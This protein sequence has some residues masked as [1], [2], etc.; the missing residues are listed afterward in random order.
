MLAKP[1]KWL[2]EKR[3][4]KSITYTGKVMNNDDPL[5]LGR[6]RVRVVE[7]YGTAEEI[8]DTDLPWINQ[9]PSSSVG[10]NSGTASF[11][12][13]EINSVVQVE[14][15]TSDPNFGYYKG[16]CNSLD[17][18]NSFFDEDYP[19]S[20]GFIDSQ[21][22]SFKINKIKNTIEVK[23]H[24][25]TK[26]TINTDGSISVFSPTTSLTG[27]VNVVGNLNV[28]TG[29]SGTFRTEDEATVTVVNGIITRIS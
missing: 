23:H 14:F 2:T 18:R 28:S 21:N 6:V 1:T 22:N 26:I 7:F 5:K 17:I 13:P 3:D 4:T 15:P 20:Y 25:G 16:G 9:E 8:P 11:S 24:T 27:T 29:A 19:N 12:V 10:G